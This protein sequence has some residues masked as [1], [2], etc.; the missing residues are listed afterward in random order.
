M[1]TQIA[2]TI[3]TKITTSS[4][5][6][7]PNSLIPKCRTNECR[8]LST[9]CSDPAMQGLSICSYQKFWECRKF[10]ADCECALIQVMSDT[11]QLMFEIEKGINHRRHSLHFTYARKIHVRG[12]CQSLSCIRALP[13]DYSFLFPISYTPTQTR[14][15]QFSITCTTHFALT[16]HCV[17]DMSRHTYSAW[18][19]RYAWC[20]K[21]AHMKKWTCSDNLLWT[22]QF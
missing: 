21:H 22:H 18:R 6:I 9:Y 19:M 14:Q 7:H 4:I 17:S 1:G 16:D 10:H 13:S 3:S 2:W 8:H 11:F 15:I 5:L 20:T 12:L